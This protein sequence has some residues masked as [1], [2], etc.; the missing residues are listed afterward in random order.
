MNALPWS[1]DELVEL[2]PVATSVAPPEYGKA[3]IVIEA[4]LEH[5]HEAIEGL[6]RF[7]SA[8]R[9]D[10]PED[11]EVYGPTMHVAIEDVAQAVL[12]HFERAELIS[13]LDPDDPVEDA[14]P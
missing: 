9:L 6:Q 1:P 3:V 7:L 13:D 8:A 2:L 11:Q 14:P 10:A 12:K 5:L 4:D